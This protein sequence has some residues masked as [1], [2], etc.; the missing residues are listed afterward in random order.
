M[1][2]TGVV[3]S[4]AHEGG[5]D[6]IA[7]EG[8]HGIADLQ[9]ARGDRLAA[10]V[11]GNGDVVQALFQISEV[12]GYGQDGHALGP[13]RDTELGLHHEAVRSSADADDDIAEALCAEVNDPPHLNARGVYVETP[14]LRETGQLLVVIVALVLHPGGHRHHGQ[15]VGVHDVVDVAGEAQ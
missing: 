14:H 15:V 2:Q 8:G 13:D 9:I 11:E 7:H 6:G 4:R 10:F 1:Y 5:V 3:L 12:F